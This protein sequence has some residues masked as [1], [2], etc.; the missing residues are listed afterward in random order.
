MLLAKNQQYQT[1]AN[2]TQDSDLPAELAKMKSFPIKEIFREDVKN[3]KLPQ[4]VMP[5]GWIFLTTILLRNEIGIRGRVLCWQ[6]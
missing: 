4:F 5:T 1:I 3:I 6:I 2:Q